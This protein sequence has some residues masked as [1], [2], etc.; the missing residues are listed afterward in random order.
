MFSPDG[1]DIF[2]TD[3]AVTLDLEQDGAMITDSK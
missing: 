3:C 2:G 1:G